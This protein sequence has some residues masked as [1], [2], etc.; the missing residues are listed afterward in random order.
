MRIQVNGKHID[1][2]E[3]L[4]SHVEGRLN[5]SVTKYSERPVEAV[6]TFSK[7]RHEFVSDATVHQTPLRLLRRSITLSTVHRKMM[8]QNLLNL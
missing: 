3:S 5:E 8:N 2:G 7:D 1:V 6:V 4:T